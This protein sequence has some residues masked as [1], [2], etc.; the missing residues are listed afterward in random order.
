MRYLFL[1]VLIFTANVCFGQMYV[2]IDKETGEVKGTV[3]VRPENI[4]GWAKIYIM[5]MVDESY[6]GKKGYEIKFEGGKLRPATPS[7]I[8]ASTVVDTS[9]QLTT[10]DMKKLKALIK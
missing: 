4:G 1:A 10:D 3:D 8:A 9:G 5:K 2:A 7:E 6:R